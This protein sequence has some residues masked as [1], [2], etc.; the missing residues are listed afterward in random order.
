MIETGNRKLHYAKK[1]VL[2]CN[3]Q[4]SGVLLLLLASKYGLFALCSQTPECFRG[5]PR[6]KGP[7]CWSPIPTSDRA[8]WLFGVLLPGVLS[9]SCVWGEKKK[10][11]LLLRTEL[12]NH[13]LRCISDVITA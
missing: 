11:V 1:A 7:G 9:K 3:S 12:G 4:S 5:H 6:I 2:K 13:C 10:K 8:V